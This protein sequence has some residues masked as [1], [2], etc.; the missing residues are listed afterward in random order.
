MLIV[1]TTADSFATACMVRVQPSMKR[2]HT[3]ADWTFLPRGQFPKR[4]NVQ[5]RADI[6]LASSFTKLLLDEL[7]LR[8][9]LLPVTVLTILVAIPNALAGRTLLEGIT[10]L[11]A[12]RTKFGWLGSRF[13]WWD[14][15]HGVP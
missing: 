12:R 11:F 6:E 7:A 9:V 3:H 4:P 15:R 1:A 13:S 2:Q 8:L 10:F 5:L 14:R